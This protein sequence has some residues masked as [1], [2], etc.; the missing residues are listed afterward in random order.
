MTPGDPPPL[1]PYEPSLTIDG[2]P[3]PRPEGRHELAIYT[4][5]ANDRELPSIDVDV[6]KNALDEVRKRAE[7]WRTGTATVLGLVF[8]TLAIKKPGDTVGAFDGWNRHAITAFIV[9]STGVGLASL[10]LILRAANGPSWLDT[11]I[12]D[13]ARA[14]GAMRFLG[15][16]EAA[17]KDLRWGQI[18]FFVALALFAVAVGLTWYLRPS[19]K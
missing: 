3:D 4:R 11:R 14:R 9:L 2:N 16:A 10:F 18:L 1:R 12:K 17:S 19:P 5:L 6:A 13:F 15:R 7:G 8:A